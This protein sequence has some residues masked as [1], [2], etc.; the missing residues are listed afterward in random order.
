MDLEAML[1]EMAPARQARIDGPDSAAAAVLENAAVTAT[2]QPAWTAPGPGQYVYVKILTGGHGVIPASDWTTPVPP[3]GRPCV[4]AQT[5]QFWVASDGSGRELADTSRCQGGAG[6][7]QRFAA[8]E[9]NYD[10]YPYAAS[11]PTDPASA[12]LE[13]EG[14]SVAYQS[15]AATRQPPFWPGEVVNYT[16]YAQSAVVNSITALP[17]PEP[18]LN[19]QGVG[20][21]N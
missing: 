6:A 10:V 12:V 4:Y 21:G 5:E 15:S 11:L 8:G 2:R 20:S 16:V 19:R 9:V 1:T 18:S 3:I 13:R 7:T 17:G 14:V